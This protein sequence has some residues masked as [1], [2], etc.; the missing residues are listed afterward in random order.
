VTRFLFWVHELES[1]LDRESHEF[2]REGKKK[3]VCLSPVKKVLLPNRLAFFIFSCQCE[4]QNSK[5]RFKYKNEKDKKWRCKKTENLPFTERFK[6]SKLS[7]KGAKLMKVLECQQLV[8]L[9]LMSIN[10]EDG[11][12]WQ[13]NRLLVSFYSHKK[14]SNHVQI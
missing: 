12:Q 1:S 11:I 3:V 9:T 5:I 2:I 7:A 10:I 6:R 4:F 13:G 8:P 14:L